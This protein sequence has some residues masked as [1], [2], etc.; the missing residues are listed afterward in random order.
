MPFAEL[1]GLAYIEKRD[2]ARPMEAPL[3]FRCVDRRDQDGISGSRP[4]KKSQKA[5]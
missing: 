1:A 4:W 3:G 2:V 5:E